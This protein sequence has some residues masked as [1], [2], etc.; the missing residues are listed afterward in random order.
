MTNFSTK[1][2]SSNLWWKLRVRE[3]FLKA[4]AYPTP[5]ILKS[6]KLSW[7]P[8]QIH[9][10]A[11][12][13]LCLLSHPPSYPLVRRQQI[14]KIILCILWQPLTLRKAP[15]QS[16]SR[17]EKEMEEEFYQSWAL[18]DNLSTRLVY[19]K[20]WN[21][22]SKLETHPERGMLKST[23]TNLKELAGAQAETML[24]TK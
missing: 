18:Q 8:T 5:G 20:M 24:T 16:V 15:N 23:G 10:S 12:W 9:C 2:G 3:T 17:F 4:D 11:R 13:P 22:V 1:M 21:Q 14:I 19:F 7:L 6:L